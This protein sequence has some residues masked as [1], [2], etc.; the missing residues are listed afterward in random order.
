MLYKDKLVGVNVEE[1]KQRGLPLEQLKAT[2][3]AMDKPNVT[4]RAEELAAV[5]FSHKAFTSAVCALIIRWAEQEGMEQSKHRAYNNVDQVRNGRDEE[6]SL[7][8]PSTYTHTHPVPFSPSPHSS[9]PDLHLHLFPLPL[10]PFSP[11]P[12]ISE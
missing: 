8:A 6:L 9:S 4:A 7:C 2:L 5:Y 10:P 1:I 3:T 11:S 12:D